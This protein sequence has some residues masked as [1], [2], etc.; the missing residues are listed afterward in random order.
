MGLPVVATESSAAHSSNVSGE[1]GV[2]VPPVDY[3]AFKMAVI[4]TSRNPEGLRTLGKTARR[5]A[6]G[7]VWNRVLGS[8]EERLMEVIR[9]NG[10]SEGRHETVAATAQ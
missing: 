6:E 10:G 3:G 4:D 8:V 2:T 7:V 1:N 5:R 9:R